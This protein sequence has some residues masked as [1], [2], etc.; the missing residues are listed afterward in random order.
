MDAEARKQIVAGLEHAMRTETD[1][2]HFYQMAAR[3]TEDP[4]GQEVFQRLAGEELDHLRFLQHQRQ[5]LIERGEIDA[6][7]ELGTPADLSGPNPIFSDRLSERIGD[8]PYEMSA[9]AIG[10]Q[11]EI[12]SERYHREQAEKAAEENIRRF[13]DHLARWEAG[14]YDALL[15]Q[16]DS[17]KQDY[18]AAGG[19]APF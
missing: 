13:Y 12:N 1:G 11:L 17:L 15:R 3:A 14:H 18:W 6:G 16:H 9:L 8:A 10:I 5:S 7:A 19:F 4:K 2:H